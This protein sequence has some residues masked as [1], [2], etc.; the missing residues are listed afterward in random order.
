MVACNLGVLVHSGGEDKGWTR[1]FLSCDRGKL[2]SSMSGTV[3][4]S[5][6]DSG[7]NIR[8]VILDQ[9]DRLDSAADFEKIEIFWIFGV[10]ITNLPLLIP[11][12]GSPPGLL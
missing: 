9:I 2:S 6:N 7:K 3:S 10:S 11:G 1:H 4:I 5:R 12:P 8:L